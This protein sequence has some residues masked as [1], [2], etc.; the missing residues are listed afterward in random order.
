MKFNSSLKHRTKKAM[1]SICLIMVGISCDPHPDELKV[2]KYLIT[3]TIRFLDVESGQ[4]SEDDSS[5]ATITYS[6]NPEIVD[7]VAREETGSEF[8]FGPVREG[9][10]RIDFKLSKEY[11]NSS[12]ETYTINYEHPG[13]DVPVTTS[14]VPIPDTILL[15]ASSNTRYFV[16]GY[17]RYEDPA[18]GILMEDSAIKVSL[19]GNGVNLQKTGSSFEL[20]ALKVG[21]YELTIDLTKENVFKSGNSVRFRYNSTISITDRDQDLGGITIPRI[22]GATKFIQGTASYTDILSESLGKS[23][24]NLKLKLTPVDASGVQI[25]TAQPF[26]ITSEYFILGPLEEGR[27]NIE[28]ENTTSNNEFGQKIYYDYSS[29]HDLSESVDTLII[30]PALAWRSNT[31]LLIQVTDEQNNPTKAG[32]C[33]Y[34]NRDFLEANIATC[35]GSLADSSSTTADG[36]M[37][38][39]N[40]D[41]LKYYFNVRSKV[42]TIILSNHDEI[43]ATS[44][45]VLVANQLNK[46]TIVI[47]QD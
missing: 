25:G 4:V 33:Y 35:A 36:K 27:F 34:T 43:D 28:L 38:I 26:D 11:T 29:I 10:Y 23:F 40:L 32:V 16:R 42:G 20:G 17:A 41:E 1:I 15:R 8:Q 5:V 19:S 14:S 3:G 37:L 21:E 13:I 45:E 7:G 39:Q 24:S 18:T 47:D 12:G 22:A 9:Q 2:G 30:S 44:S 6:S 46:H 31:A